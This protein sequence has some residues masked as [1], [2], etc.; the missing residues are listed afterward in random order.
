[1]TGSVVAI[2][3]CAVYGVGIVSGCLA[4]KFMK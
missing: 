3:W 1:M 4:S 2:V